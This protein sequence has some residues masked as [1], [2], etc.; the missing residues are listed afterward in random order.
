MTF[1][2]EIT[3]CFS[4]FF[5]A[6]A[7]HAVEELV[8]VPQREFSGQHIAEETLMLAL[9]HVI[10]VTGLVRI[11]IFHLLEIKELLAN[12]VEQPL[13]IA[14]PEEFGDEACDVFHQMKIFMRWMKECYRYKYIREEELPCRM[15]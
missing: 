2:L 14:H 5:F 4:R 6:H 11:Q 15:L 10:D 9:D 3:T 1:I 12:R 8:K 7:A 13:H